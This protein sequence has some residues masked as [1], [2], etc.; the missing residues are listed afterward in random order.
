M[1]TCY[2]RTVADKS[3]RWFIIARGPDHQNP[4]HYLPFSVKMVG[5]TVSLTEVPRCPLPRRSWQVFQNQQLPDI[6]G[7]PWLAQELH[8]CSPM[9]F[10]EG[11]SLAGRR[12]YRRI[13]RRS[14]TLSE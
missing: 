7:Q 6:L 14:Q 11:G 8:S 13:E 9:D 1:S 3:L 5:Q 2:P 10:R 4:S 12:A